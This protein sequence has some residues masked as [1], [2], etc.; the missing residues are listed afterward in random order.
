METRD[1]RRPRE[2]ALAG[3][4]ELFIGARQRTRGATGFPTL[5]NGGRNERR[6][7][8]AG[9]RS[10]DATTEESAKTGAATATDDNDVVTCL[11][12]RTVSRTALNSL[13]QQ[14]HQAA[15]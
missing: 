13:V 14:R 15:S 6:A 7:H 11:L 3:K 8:S 1:S 5:M 10:N 12:I 4:Y 9:T 2:E